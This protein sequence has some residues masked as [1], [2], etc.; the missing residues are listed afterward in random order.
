MGAR[1]PFKSV[2]I[3]VLRGRHGR[4]GGGQCATQCDYGD[5]GVGVGVA[6][7]AGRARLPASHIRR[8]KISNPTND[9]VALP[10]T[11]I[12]CRFS[13]VELHYLALLPVPQILVDTWKTNVL[14]AS[15]DALK[16]QSSFLHHS[17]AGGGLGLNTSS[18]GN[19]YHSC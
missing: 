8:Q 12:E 5:G 13:M 3:V 2:W 14:L 4:P 19:L 11:S 7:A 1:V 16:A 18:S 10:A 17:Q 9:G 15:R 6:A